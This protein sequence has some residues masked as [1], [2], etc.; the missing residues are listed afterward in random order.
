MHILFIPSWYKT[1]AVPYMGTF[2]EEQARSLMKLGHQLGIIYPEYSSFSDIFGKKHPDNFYEVDNGLP[3]YCIFVQTKIPKLRKINY[4][5]FGKEVAKV[6]KQYVEKHSIPDV[7]HAHTVFYGGIAGYHL[8]K[9]FNIPLVITEH[10]TAYIMGTINN[11][12]DRKMATEIF[13]SANASL[14]VSHNFK[15][16]IEKELSLEK[17]IFSV[18]HNLASEMFFEDFRSKSYSPG[19]TFQLF[20]NS[21]FTPRKNHKMLFDAV[22]ILSDRQVPVHLNVGGSGPTADELKEKA[23]KTGILPIV[24]F[25]GPL[26]RQQ[27]KQQLRESHAFVLTSIYETFGVVLIESLACGRPVVTTDSGGP[28]DFVNPGNGLLIRDFNPEAL[29]DAIQQLMNQYEKYDQKQISEECF[30][31]FNEMKIARELEAVYS[32]ALSKQNS[33]TT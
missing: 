30:N 31:N 20:T 29:A 11:D 8:S 28:R 3:T 4:R 19:E 2:F 26:T 1:P 12:D 18:V 25:L 21:I 14:I 7:I 32:K 6:F 10:L 13:Q 27:V 9:E 5:H 15:E 16:D 33:V 23:E 17:N 24:T 22:K